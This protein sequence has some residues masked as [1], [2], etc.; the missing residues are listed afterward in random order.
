M[1]F[2]VLFGIFVEYGEEVGPKMSH[3]NNTKE[4]TAT[5]QKSELDQFYPS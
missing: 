2:V 5:G 4:E 1:V 3:E